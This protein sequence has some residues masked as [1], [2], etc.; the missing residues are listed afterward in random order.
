MEKIIFQLLSCLCLY[1]SGIQVPVCIRKPSRSTDY[2]PVEFIYRAVG[3]Q[4]PGNGV[5]IPCRRST[6]SWQRREV[7]AKSV[8]W[9][10]A[11][12]GLRIMPRESQRTSV[13]KSKC[14]FLAPISAQSVVSKRTFKGRLFTKFIILT[15]VSN[16]CFNSGGIFLAA[17]FSRW[18][19]QWIKVVF[20]AT[21]L[22]LPKLK[23]FCQS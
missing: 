9:L 5:D 18:I 12:K 13:C 11:S 10:L 17:K 2:R 22:I 15:A 16:T 7:C 3:Q 23:C 14:S 4:T 6:V 8:D 19:T 21:S 20:G 1:D